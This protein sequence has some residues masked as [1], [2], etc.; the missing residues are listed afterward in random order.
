MTFF[1]AYSVYIKI[2]NGYIYIRRCLFL[3]DIGRTWQ[4]RNVYKEWFFTN[5]VKRLLHPSVFYKW[6]D[7]DK[8]MTGCMG[9]M[10]ERINQRMLVI[11]D[12]PI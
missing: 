11:N 1:Y 9:V 2:M 10:V 3:E 7:N 12:I 4:N 5:G 6:I 8:G